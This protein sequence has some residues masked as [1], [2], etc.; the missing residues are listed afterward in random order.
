MGLWVE[1]QS[2]IAS[3]DGNPGSAHG[4]LHDLP[5]LHP[6][7]YPNEYAFFHS[8]LYGHHKPNEHPNFNGNPDHNFYPQQYGHHQ[9]H[10]YPNKHAY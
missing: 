9:S 6:D 8:N 7:Q 10:Q 4:D 2:F 1:Q 5:F 3:G